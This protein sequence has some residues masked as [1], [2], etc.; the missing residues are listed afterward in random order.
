[1]TTGQF[2]QGSGPISFDVACDGNEPSILY[3]PRNPTGQHGCSQR[4]DVGVVCETGKI[5]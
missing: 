4:Q 3:C 5:S 1:M 2:G